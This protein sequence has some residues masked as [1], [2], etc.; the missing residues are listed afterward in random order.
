ML[1]CC[2][3]RPG[4]T[5]LHI[6]IE[7]RCRPYVELLLERGAD[8]H[9]QA[10]GRFFQPRDEGGYFYFGMHPLCGSAGRTS[11]RGSADPYSVPSPLEPSRTQQRGSTASRSLQRGSAEPYSVVLLNPTAWFCQ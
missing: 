2:C 3:V 9:A 10:R 5:A 1:L 6:A 11:R 7:R 4:Q 8:V